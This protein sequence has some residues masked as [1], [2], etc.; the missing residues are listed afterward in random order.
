[1][2]KNSYYEK[3]GSLLSDPSSGEKHFWNAFKKLANKK[4]TTNI[5][6][7]IENDVYITK[8]YL[9]SRGTD[10]RSLKFPN[11]FMFNGWIF[12]CYEFLSSSR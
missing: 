10:C 7:I 5:P 9:K 1:M 8:V 2:Q 4:Q 3:L 6:P 12:T 11:L